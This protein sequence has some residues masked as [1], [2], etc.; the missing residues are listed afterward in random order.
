[1]RDRADKLHGFATAGAQGRYS[2]IIHGITVANLRGE[3]FDLD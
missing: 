1:M 2:F 3:R